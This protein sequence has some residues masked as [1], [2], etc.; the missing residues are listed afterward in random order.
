MEFF[1]GGL[2]RPPRYRAPPSGDERAGRGH[3]TTVTSCQQQGPES[4]P[5]LSSGKSSYIKAY[6]GPFYG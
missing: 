4:L 5:A 2:T 3:P 6:K 1:N